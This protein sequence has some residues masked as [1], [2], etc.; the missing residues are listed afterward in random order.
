MRNK[1]LLVD[2]EEDLAET[3]K[4]FLEEAG[5]K[6]D[7]AKDGLEAMEKIYENQYDLILLDIAIPEINGYQVLRMIKNEPLYKDVPVVMVTAKTLK[8]DKF[9]SI[10]T[11]ADEYLTKPYS[12][13]E[14]ISI[15][16]SFTNERRNREA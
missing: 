10:E 13:D 8:A 5:Y 2:D 11:G 4:M 15:V 7:I 9:R 12:P 14:L 16:R 1:I 6:V 3:Q